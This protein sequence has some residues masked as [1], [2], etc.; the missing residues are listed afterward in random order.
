[1]KPDTDSQDN[2]P[3]VKG[4]FTGIQTFSLSGIVH[5]KALSGG[6][7]TMAMKLFRAH[8]KEFAVIK[9]TQ[10]KGPVLSFL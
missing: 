9:I 7:K 8:S 6:G 10:D 3:K 4:T 5:T 1:M 2:G